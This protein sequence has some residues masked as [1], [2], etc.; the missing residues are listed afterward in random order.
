MPCPAPPAAEG[1]AVESPTV[2][3]LWIGSYPPA[4]IGTPPGRGEG[5]FRVDLDLATGALG[6][7]RRVLEA[8]APSFVVRR[9]DG[10]VLYATDESEAGRVAA[11]RVHDDGLEPLGTASSGGTYPCHLLLDGD[12]LY[13]AN[14]GDGA[15]GVLTLAPSGAFASD[16]PQVLPHAGT[17]PD[18]DRQQGPHAHFVAL[19]P[20]GSVLVVDLG[21]DEVRRHTRTA[22]GLE[23]AGIAATLPPGTGP[24]H[25][26]FGGPSAL[27]A[28]PGA[29]LAYLTGELDS[30]VHV[31]SWDP[32]TDTGEV[33]QTLPAL[34]TAAGRRS[35]GPGDT[36]DESDLRAEWADDDAPSP[37]HL[38]FDGREL[39]VGVRGPD[40]L[41]RFVVGDD[42]LLTHRGVQP[43]P[44]RTPRHFAVV[45]DWTVVA[46]QV[47]GAITVLDRRGAVASSY[48]V[49]SAACVAPAV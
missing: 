10:E 29:S 3:T 1:H 45:G 26:V 18:D 25:L 37:S 34:G 46:E 22:D 33:I 39:V 23:A 17:G 4:G 35:G 43:L 36:A 31:L 7:P 27:G 15:L 30:T 49:P 11:F 40:V 8:P 2:T 42:G 24:R 41:S 44:A 13:V 16:E 20:G 5:I 19:A 21:T 48:A 14:Y 38:A 28:S 9:P 47:P 12:R 6:E 32:A